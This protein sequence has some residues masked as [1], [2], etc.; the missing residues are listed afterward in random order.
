VIDRRAKAEN[1]RVTK[2]IEALVTFQ[3]QRAEFKEY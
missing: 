3:R 1:R 2:R